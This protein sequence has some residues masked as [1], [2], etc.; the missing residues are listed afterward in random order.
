MVT[1]IREHKDGTITGRAGEETTRSSPFQGLM[2]FSEED[3]A[4]FF[5][6]RSDIRV[7]SS[8]LLASRLTIL[9]GPSGVGKTSLLRAGVVTHVD[10]LAQRSAG[11][12][13]TPMFAVAAFDAW[14]DRDPVRG[15]LDAINASTASF[16]P[17][18]PDADENIIECLR[19]ITESSHTT[20]LLIFDQFEEYFQYH[21]SKVEQFSSQLIETI[22]SDQI[23]VHVLIAIREDRL[24]QLDHFKGHIP[25]L[26]D[27]YLRID[28]LTREQARQAVIE[29]LAH[30]SKHTG[31]TVTAEPELVEAVLDQVSVG[32]VTL[33]E[34]GSGLVESGPHP[35][36]ER[37]EATY[38]QLV[39]SRIWEEEME[40]NST[41]LRAE[42]LERL[43]GA[44][45]IVQ[46]HLD[47]SLATLS[48][49]ERDIAAAVFDRLVTPS[50]TKIAQGTEDLCAWADRELERARLYKRR[51]RL[52]RRLFWWRKI[53]PKSIVTRDEVDS[54]LRRL[55]SGDFRILRSVATQSSDDE[56]S[57]RFEIFH[58]V[59]GPP[60]VGWSGR[61]LQARRTVQR[62]GRRSV[63]FGIPTILVMS[64]LALALLGSPTDDEFGLVLWVVAA[65]GAPLLL[66]SLVFGM[67]GVGA[68]RGRRQPRGRPLAGLTLGLVSILI[69]AAAA[70]SRPTP[71]TLRINESPALAIT[72]GEVF[73]E[74]V[75]EASYSVD[76]ESGHVLTL[77]A[78]PKGLTSFSVRVAAPDGAVVFERELESASADAAIETA[79]EVA[80]SGQ[81]EITMQRLDG[82]GSATLDVGVTRQRID[83]GDV[84]DGDL[85]SA[86]T[87]VYTLTA[88]GPVVIE[89]RSGDIDAVAAVTTAAG[90]PVAQNDDTPIGNSLDSF[91]VTT[92]P[93]APDARH[94]VFHVAVSS[95]DGAGGAYELSVRRAEV[96]VAA[97]RVAATLSPSTPTL[98]YVLDLSIAS[99]TIEPSG[100]ATAAATFADADGELEATDH[101]VGPNLL[102]RV[103]RGYE[104]LVLTGD[105]GVTIAADGAET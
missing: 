44:R 65:L 35:N 8:N 22:T 99:V 26:F 69:V 28:H 83:V 19:R 81:H 17:P 104:V 66:P 24:A 21:G 57:T 52:R 49:R 53:E 98:A 70:V 6:R 76:A 95:F 10:S 20:I 79:I 50:G 18:R 105:G 96:L 25:F 56:L 74:D 15:V 43:G 29:P 71:A 30:H 38:L 40:A 54:A 87:D 37:Y 4:Y 68:A 51:G 16:A 88:G 91:I 5:G 94:G 27:N 31:R 62:F 47:R 13:G 63:R 101:R 41:T 78:S 61:H 59:L 23:D 89:V 103:P 82:D 45:S 11:A 85:P 73:T 72:E 67:L 102:V 3:A 9:Y 80:Q 1:S 42:T 92:L 14:R 77:S 58:D 48:T 75:D 84:V 64:L 46:Q 39:I 97:D 93:T 100:D 7:V 2:P 32:Q 33:Q 86:D 36:D 55:A 12:D 34:H 90:E 60:I